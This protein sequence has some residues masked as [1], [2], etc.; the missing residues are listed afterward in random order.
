[1]VEAGHLPRSKGKAENQMRVLR[2]FCFLRLPSGEYVS[3]TSLL[4]LRAKR[5]DTHKIH[6]NIAVA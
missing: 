6:A 3:L 2:L 5:P 4:F 1:M